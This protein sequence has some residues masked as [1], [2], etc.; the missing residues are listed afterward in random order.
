MNT[1]E[2]VLFM[3]MMKVL[4]FCKL[5]LFLFGAPVYMGGLVASS[6]LQLEMT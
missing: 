5:A 4:K 1:F 2:I 3:H 6:N